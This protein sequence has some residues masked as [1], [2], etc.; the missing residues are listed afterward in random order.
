MEDRTL[1]TTQPSIYPQDP[2]FLSGCFPLTSRFEGSTKSFSLPTIINLSSAPWSAQG[3]CWHCHN[4]HM[5]KK[6][7]VIAWAP[8]EHHKSLQ[9]MTNLGLRCSKEVSQ[10]R[11]LCSQMICMAIPAWGTGSITSVRCNHSGYSP[12]SAYSFPASRPHYSSQT[13]VRRNILFGAKSHHLPVPTQAGV[14]V[15]PLLD[16]SHCL[17]LLH[18]WDWDSWPLSSG[19]L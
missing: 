10:D 17:S 1:P 2:Q 16:F 15:L 6:K 13:F 14:L 19:L 11:K 5:D 4:T 18:K 8:D 7:S 9:S 12:S 3:L